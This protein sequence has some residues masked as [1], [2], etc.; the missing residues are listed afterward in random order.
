MLVPDSALDTNQNIK[1]VRVLR[2]DHSIEAAHRHARLALWPVSAQSIQ[3][4]AADELV[5]VNGLQR[6][7]PDTKVNPQEVTLDP[8]TLHLTAGGSAATQSLPATRFLPATAPTR[9]PPAL[10]PPRVPP[11]A[12]H[13][14]PLH[15]PA[16]N[17]GGAK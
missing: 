12:P 13:L 9:A 17:D 5:V 10:P 3:D 1:F 11:S 4:L 16:D 14:P 6:A 7:I 2:P 8:N 15:T